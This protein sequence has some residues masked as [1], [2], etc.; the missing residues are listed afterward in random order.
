MTA[1]Y[2]HRDP[3]TIVVHPLFPVRVNL[4]GGENNC[5]PDLSRRT[6]KVSLTTGTRR[7]SNHEDKSFT[8]T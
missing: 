5:D 3:A 1:S 7:T 6:E 2:L 4:S 8:R